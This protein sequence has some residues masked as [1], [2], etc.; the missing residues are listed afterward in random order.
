MLINFLKLVVIMFIGWGPSANIALGDDNSVRTYRSVSDDPYAPIVPVVGN[1]SELDGIKDP[2]TKA[3]LVT[4]KKRL[5]PAKKKPKYKTSRIRFQ[6]VNVTGRKSQP[7]VAFR[8]RPLKL[9]RADRE[10]KKSFY[11]KIFAV[12]P[13]L[14]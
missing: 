7:R 10:L 11:R 1:P 8:R 3:S 2:I 4:T 6:Q 13:G 12:E 5:A 14:Q 9:E